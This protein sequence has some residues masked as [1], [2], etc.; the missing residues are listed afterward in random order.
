MS[1]RSITSYFGGV[2]HRFIKSNNNKSLTKFAVSFSK[3]YNENIRNVCKTHQFMYIPDKSI[4]ITDRSIFSIRKQQGL[5]PGININNLPPNSKKITESILE[6]VMKYNIKFYQPIYAIKISG[7]INI[8]DG[9]HRFIAIN[10][11]QEK[12]DFISLMIILINEN[13]DPVELVLPKDIFSFDRLKMIE[14]FII[15]EG[16]SNFSDEF[17]IIDTYN[18]GD[19]EY[20]KVKIIGVQLLKYITIICSFIMDSLYKYHYN[21]AIKFDP[22]KVIN[23]KII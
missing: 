20:F 4:D 6:S 13:N 11:L 10:E 2:I 23:N 1:E 22:P 21:G 19:I 7:V 14:Q 8:Y 16:K 3:A 5:Y 18:I 17:Q 15:N 12:K 9:V